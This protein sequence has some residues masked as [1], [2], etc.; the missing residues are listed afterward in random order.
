ME[1]LLANFGQ[2]ELHGFSLDQKRLCYCADGND[3]STTGAVVNGS[4]R[5]LEYFLNSCYFVR[6]LSDVPKL[7]LRFYNLSQSSRLNDSQCHTLSRY[8]A[9]TPRVV[10]IEYSTGTACPCG[11]LVHR[12]KHQSVLL[13]CSQCTSNHRNL[14][15]PQALLKSCC[16][17]V[18]PGSF[19][20]PSELQSYD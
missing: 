8:D 11:H 12:T 19:N 2:C 1:N 17:S 20:D 15:V 16:I 13:V 6:F 9:A 7:L 14:D 18:H 4:S 3:E 10:W 5:F